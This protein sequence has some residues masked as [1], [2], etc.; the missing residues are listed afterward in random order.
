MSQNKPTNPDVLVLEE[1]VFSI[2]LSLSSIRW[3]RGPGRGGAA[4]V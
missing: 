4:K 3:R 1:Y 2:A